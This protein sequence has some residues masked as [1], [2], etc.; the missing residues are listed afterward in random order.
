MDGAILY[1]QRFYASR[2]YRPCFYLTTFRPDGNPVAMF[3][4]LFRRQ[5]F[6]NLGEQFRLFFLMIRRPPRHGPTHVMLGEPVGGNRIGILRVSGSVLWIVPPAPVLHD[7]IGRHFGIE[8]IY[9]GGLY[10]LI[11]R[12]Q[13][14]IGQSTRN[15][16]PASTFTHHYKWIRS[17]MRIQSTP[18]RVSFSSRRLRLR[19]VWHIVPNPTPF[20]AIPIIVFRVPPDIFLALGPRLAFRISGGTII[21]N[22]PVRG[23]RK[24]P[25]RADIRI[26]MAT[27]RQVLSLFGHNAA[28]NPTATGSAAIRPEFGIVFDNLVIGNRVTIDLLHDIFDNGFLQR[29]RAAIIP[30][31]VLNRLVTL[32]RT[33]LIAFLKAHAE[34]RQEPVLRPCITWC[35]YS[36]ITVLD[37]ALRIGKTALF[38]HMCC[39][40]KEDDLRRNPGRINA[41]P[42]PKSC[43]FNF[44]EVSYN[45]PVQLLQSGTVEASVHTACP[46]VLA[47]REVTFHLPIL[48]RD[49]HGQVRVI[50]YDLGKVVE[51]P[52]ILLRGCIP[53]P[54]F[55]ETHKVLRIVNP[56]A[57]FLA[58]MLH[59]RI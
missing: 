32:L 23:P 40:R 19:K 35:V 33:V 28:E 17:R 58:V 18:H 37:E 42:F 24:A 11:M 57:C 27:P 12:G 21:K 6:A 46:R 13:W 22:V 59:I 14:S 52:V 44:V 7:R 48:H 54:R 36:L 15:E 2:D 49:K 20:C 10:R 9:D 50:L 1:L 34:F 26:G 4:S 3:D 8:Q 29:S 41:W 55:H 5:F 30:D 25:A 43:R 16:E 53:V 39:R 45:H 51:G 31:Q 47:L 56:P 38:I